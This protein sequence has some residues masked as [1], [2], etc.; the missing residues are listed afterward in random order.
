MTA[1]QARR[2]HLERRVCAD[3]DRLKDTLMTQTHN[4]FVVAQFYGRAICADGVDPELTRTN[5]VDRIRTKQY[6]PIAFIHL[7]HGGMCEDVTNEL[8]IEAG[9]Y[10]EPMPPS[11]RLAALHDYAQDTRKNWRS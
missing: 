3:L 5:I 10:D 8:L 1:A 2:R 11:D 7:C 4:Y 9:F 6:G